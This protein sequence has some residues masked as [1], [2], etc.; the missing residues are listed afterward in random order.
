MRLRA[1]DGGHRRSWRLVVTV[2]TL[3]GATS[4]VVA[5]GATTGAARQS[6]PASVLIFHQTGSPDLRHASIEYGIAAIQEMGARHDFTVAETQ[7]SAVFTDASL[8]RYDAIVW[9]NVIAPSLD[10][11]QR[12][13]FERYIAGGGGFVGVHGPA[14]METNWPWYY[15]ELIGTFYHSH[16]YPPEFPVT[17]HATIAVEDRTHPSTAHLPDRWEFTEEWWNFYGSPR[18]EVHVLASLDES[19][20]APGPGAMGDHP[21]TWCHTPAGGRAWYTNLGHSV[22]TYA[23]QGFRQHLLGGI[24]YATGQA[25]GD[26]SPPGRDGD[27]AFDRRTLAEGADLVGEP[28]DLAVLP[29]RRVV[30][31]SR[32]GQVW[33]TDPDGTTTP[34]GTLPDARVYSV[35]ID[36]GFARDKWVYVYYTAADGHR[37]SRF[38]LRRNGRLD[39]AGEQRILLVPAESDSGPAGGDI[40]FDGDGNLLL[41]TTDDTSSSTSDGFTPVDERAGRQT[42]DAQRSAANTNDLRGKLLRVTVDRDGGHTIPDGNLFPPGTAKTRPEIYAMGLRD[43]ERFSV[44]TRTGWIQLGDLGPDAG[45]AVPARGP[46]GQAELNL[47]K[48]P[49]NYGWPYCAGDNQPYV[50]HDFATGQPGAAFD[51]AAPKNNSPN[52]TGLVDLPPARAAWLAYDG[53]SVPELNSGGSAPAF[54][55]GGEAPMGGPTYHFDPALDSATKF[56]ASYDGA[57]IPYERDRGWL[58]DIAVGPAGERGRITPVLDSLALGRPVDVEFG[59]DG[60]LYVLDAD[61]GHPALY[62]V[63]HVPGNRAPSVELTADRT[64]GPGPM[65]VAF[66]PAG[67]YDPEDDRLRYAWDFDGDG[68]V[69]STTP[70]ATRHRYHRPGEYTARLSVTDAAGNTGVATSTVVVGNT[71]PTVTLDA[72]VDGV[73]AGPGDTVPFAVSVT[74]QEDGRVDCAR[75]IVEYIVG[76][77]VRSA[78]TGCSGALAVP[79]GPSW[80][81][82]M[83][84]ARYTDTG[85]RGAPRLSGSA[86]HVLHGDVQEAESVTEAYGVRVAPHAGASGGARIGDIDPGDW[87]KFDRANLAG[88]TGIGFR[89][90]ASAAG[91]RIEV[92]YHEVGG[93]TLL[94]VDVPATGSADTYVELP[95]VAL[96]DPGITEPLYVMFKGSARGVFTVDTVVFHKG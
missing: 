35:A 7:D 73:F 81:V 92:Q 71:R 16:P 64:S 67:T 40:G 94:A 58:K 66:H 3:L 82:G 17:Q 46:A 52:N 14:G 77:E 63:D 56:P 89:V 23:D 59:P 74:D 80:P 86:S 31:A 42:H 36:P 45:A 30:H 88:V 32:T 95:A 9:L 39:L 79:D 47:I 85:G 65:T 6:A 93:P 2:L 25:S 78:A 83:V 28:A 43:P 4:G 20:Y 70:G 62:R 69:D 57:T 61:A 68:H 84:T 22:E 27:T 96:A 5:S 53:G 48:E 21:V 87:I 90:S 24:R 55:S 76:G 91:G 15:N 13:A 29:D 44:D 18:P 8:A 50:H 12:A 38:A 72:P 26:C 19:T 34:A 10:G 11:A 33:L 1:E 49:G 54:G 75:V 41:S 51:C 37:L 60:S